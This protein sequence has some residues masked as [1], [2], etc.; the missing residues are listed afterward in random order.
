MMNEIGA[1]AQKK[2]VVVTGKGGSGKSLVALSL[3]HRFSMMN[4]RVWLVETG[5]RRDQ[6]FTRL[7]ELVGK[8]TLQHE[9]TA[10]LLPGSTQ[11]IHVSVLDPTKSLIEYVGLKLPAGGLAG[12]LLNNK[13][14]AS[15][16]EVVPGLPDMVS[17]GKLW[18]ALQKPDPVIGPDIVVLDAP[19]TGHAV[20]LLKSPSNFRRIT[21]AGPIYRD[22][23]LMEQFLSREE[24]T[25]IVL[26]T[27]PEEMS[28]QETLDLRALLEKEF[29]KPHVIVNKCFPELPP[30]EEEKDTL[31]FRTYAY[32]AK[33]AER[34]QAAV[35]A[36]RSGP[37]TEIPFFFPDPD[38]APLYQRISEAL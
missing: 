13:V 16:L 23:L 28:I 31:P 22:A 2:L 12:L 24:D 5:R 21:R 29:P 35:K 10:V 32:A 27:L 20:S 11:R 15:F 36:L 8:K 34:E 6:A 1:L 30:L 3:A 37:R 14:T 38:G 4:K 19:A 33:R 18:Y 26:T 25:G 7:P 9:P 17:L